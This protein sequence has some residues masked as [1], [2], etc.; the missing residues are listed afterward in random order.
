MCTQIRIYA[1]G[2]IVAGGNER[3]VFSNAL[4]SVRLDYRTTEPG[5]QDLDRINTIAELANV[6]ATEPRRAVSA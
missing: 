4:P 6:P 5:T 1:D 2:V 3:Y